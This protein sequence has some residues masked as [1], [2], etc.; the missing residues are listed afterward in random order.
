MELNGK[1]AL[2]TGGAVRVGRAIVLALAEAGCNVL[3]HYGRSAGPAQETQADAIALRVEA[4]IYSADLSDDEAVQSIIPEAKRRFGQVDILINNAAVFPE[5]DTFGDTDSSLWEKLFNINLRA[6]FRLSQAFAAQIPEDGRGKII[7]IVD[8]RVRRPETDH[9]VYRLTKGA[10]WQMTEMMSLELAPR[11]TANA[12]ALG[13]I[14]PPPGAEQAYLEKLAQTRIPL[15]RAGSTQIVTENV[16]HL[17]KQ[18]FLT[19]V[20]IPVDGGEFL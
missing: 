11:I 17:L 16:L 5:T 9:F 4:F 14:L 18:D 6:P 7:N 20:T 19:G 13:A 2:V 15:K 1:A 3:I 8:A 12:V 10:L